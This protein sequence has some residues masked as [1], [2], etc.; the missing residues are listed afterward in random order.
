MSTIEADRTTSPSVELGSRGT[1]EVR[2][3]AAWIDPAMPRGIL[4]RIYLDRRGSASRPKLIFSVLLLD[5]LLVAVAGLMA[6]F[7]AAPGAAPVVAPL[8]REGLV[9]L[10]IVVV[11]QGSWSYTI[12]SLR[13][14]AVQVERIAKAVIAVFGM[15]AGIGYLSGLHL[16]SPAAGLVWLTTSAALLVATRLPVAHVLDRL[17]LAGHLVRRTVI[18]GGGAEAEAIIRALEHDPVPQVQILG[19]FDDRSDERSSDSFCGYAKLGNFSQLSAFCQRAGVD[20]LIVTV[21]VAAERRLLEVLDRL[22]AIPA[23]IR[24]SALGSRLRLN[25]RAYTHVGSVPMLAVMD[26][27]LTDWDRIV[28]NLEDRIIGALLLVLLAPVMALVALA[29]R[30]DS[31][32]PILFKQ[33]RY[34]FDNELIEVYKFRSMFTDTSDA[35]ASKLVSKDDAR[36]TRVGRF[37]RR[38]SL[39]ELPQ[40]FNVLK[41]EM[42]LVG[43]RPH[44][45]GAKAQSDLYQSVVHGY[46]AR[47]RVKP[48]LTGW[49][50]IKGWRG[51]TDTHEKIVRRVEHDLYYIDNWSLAFDLYVLAVTPL[52]LLT[53]R[54]AY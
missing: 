44:A 37:I 28:K 11:L 1:G 40:L 4:S 24:I 27:P 29:V 5:V 30:L 9:A 25:A 32:G 34:G 12:A 22:F 47:H 54:N 18:V 20:L 50:Q 16:F 31:K 36:V 48:G 46:F 53:G 15:A 21:P 35:T 10:A 51:E 6:A 8:V 2:A 17:S 13:R 3:P 7:I 49:A 26:R 38:T 41:G 23:D 39:D 42:S 19:V 43:P 33:R 45:T 52:A 14:P